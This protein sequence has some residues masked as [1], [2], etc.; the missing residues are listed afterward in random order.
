MGDTSKPETKHQ[1]Q[2]RH[3]REDDTL[4]PEE[5]DAAPGVVRDVQEL[6]K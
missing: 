1:R 6:D 3:D 2:A 4:T 5:R